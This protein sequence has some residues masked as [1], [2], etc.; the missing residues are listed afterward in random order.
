MMILKSLLKKLKRKC[1]ALKIKLRKKKQTKFAKSAAEI[2]LSKSADSANFLLAPAI[3][4]VKIQSH[5]FSGLKAKCLNAAATSMKK[6]KRGSSF[7]GCSNYP[8]CN[9]MTWDAPSDEVCPRC[10]KSLFKRKEAMCFIAPIQKGCGF[11][12]PAPRKENRR[13]NGNLYEI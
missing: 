2:W 13:I 1:R 6:T 11:T 9:F 4:N 3:R 7:Y 5:L 12:K 10:G 8:K